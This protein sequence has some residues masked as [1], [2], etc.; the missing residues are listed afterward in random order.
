MPPQAAGWCRRRRR[1]GAA[2]RRGGAGATPGWSR[3]SK[4]IRD[5]FQHAFEILS[6]LSIL[7][8]QNSNPHPA[9]EFA[10][11]RITVLCRFM[12][13]RGAVQFYSQ[14]L[15]GTVEIQNGAT[16]TVLASEFSPLDLPVLEMDPKQRF[17]RSQSRTK[18]PPAILARRKVVKAHPA[19]N[20]GVS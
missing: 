20:A 5:C 18:R 8:A 14:I 10:A 4:A 3:N 9:Q 7:E 19:G 2:R 15:S 13:V 12:V 11:L 6:N 17:G 16:D 1:G